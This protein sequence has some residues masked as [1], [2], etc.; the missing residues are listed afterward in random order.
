MEI[1]G[2][3]LIITGAFGIIVVLLIDIHN[4]NRKNKNN[5]NKYQNGKK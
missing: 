3:F 5:L 4:Q 2:I 1:L